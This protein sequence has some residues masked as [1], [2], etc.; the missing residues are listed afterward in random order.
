[1]Q[2]VV[3]LAGT[4][5]LTMPRGQGWHVVE[6]FPVEQSELTLQ[7][8]FAAHLGHVPPQST[9]LSLPFRILSL[10]LAI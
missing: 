9:S 4:G 1:M 6:Q 7:V 5:T 10:Q 8:A 3:V 2:Y